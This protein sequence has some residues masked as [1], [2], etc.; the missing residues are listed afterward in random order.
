[1]LFRSDVS[2]VTVSLKTPDG[3]LQVLLLV[4]DVIP[5]W[6]TPYIL[7]QP[8]TVKDGG[9]LSVAYG[10]N[11]APSADVSRLKFTVSTL[12]PAAPARR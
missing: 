8:L 11:A 4:R 3:R 7:R 6:P 9:E 2:S 10:L 12:P 5:E 1:M